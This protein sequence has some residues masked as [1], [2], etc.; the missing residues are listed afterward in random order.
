M[1]HTQSLLGYCLVEL[2]E[3]GPHPPPQ[4]G[5]FTNSLH[6]APGKA[7]DMRHQPVKAAEREAV[8]CKATGTELPKA[9]GTNL[10]HQR[11]D[12]DDCWK[13]TED[14]MLH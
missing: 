5:R 4:N 7:T 11:D 6:P 9:M 2:R 12:L 8:P 10:L 14:Y 13:V 1:P 3:E